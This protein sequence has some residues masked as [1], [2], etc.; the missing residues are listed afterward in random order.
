MQVQEG[1]NRIIEMLGQCL[2]VVMLLVDFWDEMRLGISR[3]G[4]RLCGPFARNRELSELMITSL[5]QRGVKIL[6]TRG[7]SCAPHVGRTGFDDVH[8]CRNP[9]SGER[10]DGGG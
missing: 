1:T 10:M 2:Q 9:S 4:W 3:C 6:D 5:V 7:F 8:A